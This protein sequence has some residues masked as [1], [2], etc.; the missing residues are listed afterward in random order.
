MENAVKNVLCEHLISDM[1]GVRSR[2]GENRTLR[3]REWSQRSELTMFN[4]LVLAALEKLPCCRCPSF[5]RP[6]RGR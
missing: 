6:D 1:V 5:H 3:H 2:D 4:T